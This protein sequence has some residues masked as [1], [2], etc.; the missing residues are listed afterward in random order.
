MRDTIYTIGHSNL[1]LGLFLDLL[2]GHRIEILLDVRSA[3]YSRRLPHFN[4][5]ALQAMLQGEA[6][7][8]VYLGN[9]LGGRPADLEI[10]AGGRVQYDRVMRTAA[11]R[12]GIAR[13][14]ATAADGRVALMCAEKDPLHC[15][16]MLLVGRALKE[17]GVDVVHILGDGRLESMEQT[18]GRMFAAAGVSEDDLFETREERLA[19]AYGAW[20]AALGR[21]E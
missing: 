8:Y 20:A 3:P 4:R 6:L 17:R 11:F 2:R 21:R 14:I 10:H 12:E 5:E 18:E 13:A 19:R 16:R 7:R 15:H 1:D 9:Q